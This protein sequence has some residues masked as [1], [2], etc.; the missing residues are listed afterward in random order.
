MHSSSGACS[1]TPMQQMTAF[2]SRGELALQRCC[3]CNA[4]QYPPR[5][6]CVACL[7][8]R[9]EWRATGAEYGEVLADTTLHHSHEATFRDALPLRVGLVRLDPGP[10]AVCFLSEGC[11]AGTRVRITAHNDTLGRAVLSAAPI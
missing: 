3:D 11:D 6:L 2:A 7:G 10:T 4:T 8:E 9:L 1:V 5:E